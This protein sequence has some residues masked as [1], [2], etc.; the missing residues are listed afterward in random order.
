MVEKGSNAEVSSII[1]Y[2]PCFIHFVTE[3]YFPHQLGKSV[4]LEG[5]SDNFPRKLW[6]GIFFFQFFPLILVGVFLLFFF[7]KYC[8]DHY[9]HSFAAQVNCHIEW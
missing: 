2:S 7:K 5:D 4:V 3:V 9:Q 8:S 1:N 6:V